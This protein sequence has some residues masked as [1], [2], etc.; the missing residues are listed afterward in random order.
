MHFSI[1][2]F[3]ALFICLFVVLLIMGTPVC[4][5]DVTGKVTGEAVDEK[6]LPLPFVQVSLKRSTDSTLVKTLLADEKGHFAFIT[7]RGS[8]F[9]VLN[10]MGY[11]TVFSKVF[12][13][14]NLH[15][16][17]L[18][19]IQLNLDAKQL[20]TVSIAAALP[21]IE[22][23][24]DKLV[25]N[26]NGM[27]SGA[28]IMEVM[29]QLPGVSV[30]P[31]DRISLNGKSVQIYIDGKATTLSTEALAGMLKGISSSAIQKV[32]LIAQPSAKYDAAGNGAIIN[33][34]RKRNYNAGWN[35]NIYGGRGKG[36]VWQGKWRY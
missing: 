36:Y 25:V 3:S 27:G 12:E 4:A 8:Y 24:A 30:T 28:A 1:L 31:D 17:P 5:Q 32:E 20:S 22:R 10:M 23:R 9:V 16:E 19:T 15:T 11:G 33:I 34:I 18:G 35:G 13:I 29:N 21:F 2:K 26:L 6:Y 7:G 14:T